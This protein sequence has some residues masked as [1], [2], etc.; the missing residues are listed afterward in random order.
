MKKIIS[1]L[2]VFILIV[3]VSTLSFAQYS[4]PSE[5]AQESVDKLKMTFDFKGSI[6]ADYSGN[7]SRGEFIYLAVKL[8]SY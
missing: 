4:R 1:L 2:L 6:F 7:I 3:S 5:W 8:M